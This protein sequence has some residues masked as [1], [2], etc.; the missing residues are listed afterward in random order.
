MQSFNTIFPRYGIVNQKQESR[1][2]ELEVDMIE[3][4]L[5]FFQRT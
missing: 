3:R 4:G 2:P 5:R 1:S